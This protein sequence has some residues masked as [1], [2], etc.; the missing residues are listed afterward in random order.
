LISFL[1]HM[2]KSKVVSG[3]SYEGFPGLEEK[4]FEALL[5]WT[6]LIY[7]GKT[8][9]VFKFFWLKVDTPPEWKGSSP[10]GYANLIK[11]A[12]ADAKKE[13]EAKT[14][15]SGYPR[16]VVDNSSMAK[17]MNPKLHKASLKLAYW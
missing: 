9:P 16:D 7:I 6:E 11:E 3:A 5:T 14:K 8:N 17:F 13:E 1:V 2:L 10:G 4:G 15:D 12:E